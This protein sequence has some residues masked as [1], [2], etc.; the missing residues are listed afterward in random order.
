M[1]F[2]ILRRNENGD[3]HV[4]S[5][6]TSV[7]MDGHSTREAAKAA[8]RVLYEGRDGEIVEARGSTEGL[9]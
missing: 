7:D 8:A 9:L 4:R 2:Y 3:P 5:S 6:M 1:P